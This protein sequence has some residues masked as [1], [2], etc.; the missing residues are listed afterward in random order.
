MKKISILVP[1]YNEV[2]NINAIYEALKNVLIQL[3]EYDW[4]ITFIDNK[5]S[6]GS[7]DLIREICKNDKKVKA[8]LNSKNFG[9]S[10]SPY[11]GICQ[12]DGDC[13]IMISADL[14]DPPELIP[15]MIK[16]WE[17]GHDVVTT[18]KTSDRESKVVR[19]CRTVYY[20]ILKKMSDVEIIEHFT[21]FGLYDKSFVN[22]MRSLDDPTPFLRGVVAEY[23][24]SIS[25]VSYEHRERKSGQSKFRFAQ[26]YDLAMLSFTSY[27]TFGLRMASFIGYIVAIF[28]FLVAAAYFVIKLFNWDS[29]NPGSAATLIGMFFLGAIQLI[30]MGFLGEYII[31]INRRSM[32]R[33]LVVEEERI[34]YADDVTETI[35]SQESKC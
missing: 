16:E 29:F 35:K 11:Y 10:N 30:F 15:Q 21:G 7:R 2:G 9:G 34:N 12:T 1:T 20:R 6:D 18:V 17:K 27:T 22:I 4:D 31:S 5:S 8:I 24:S 33:P 19:L 32:H 28:S 26:L 3:T 14:Q 25:S 23:A 13:T